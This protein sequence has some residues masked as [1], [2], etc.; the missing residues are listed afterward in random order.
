MIGRGAIRNPWLFTQL[1][2]TWDT[3]VVQTQPTL[4]D[5]RDYIQRLHEAT[6]LPGVRELGQVGKMKKYLGYI[7][8]G[9]NGSDAFWNELKPVLTLRELF[10]VCDRHLLRD[11]SAFGLR[12]ERE[13]GSSPASRMEPTAARVPTS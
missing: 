3:G 5:L 7:A 13:S 2:E 8:P 10:E 11:G 9:I 1:R 12:P 4:A 6:Q